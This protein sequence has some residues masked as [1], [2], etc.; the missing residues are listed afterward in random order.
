VVTGVIVLPPLH[1]RAIFL[2]ILGG[3]CAYLLM[4]GTSSKVPNGLRHRLIPDE[5]S[6]PFARGLVQEA[7]FTT[8]II[9]LIV[10]PYR[11]V[12]NPNEPLPELIFGR[13]VLPWL[14]YFTVM[15]IFIALKYPGSL[16]DSTWIQVRGI[17]AGLLVMFSLCGGMFF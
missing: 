3:A 16:R 2:V 9:G 6:T 7:L 13:F 1:W 15:A 10:L 8:F 11:I 5:K 14:V 12:V 17:V 4:F